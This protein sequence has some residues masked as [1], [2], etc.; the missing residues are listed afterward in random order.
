MLPSLYPTH[1]ADAPLLTP[2][3]M[4]ALERAAEIAALFSALSMQFNNHNACCNNTGFVPQTERTCSSKPYPTTITK[5]PK[6]DNHTA[7]ATGRAA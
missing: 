5:R 3:A 6:N 2:L 1:G 4:T 7:T